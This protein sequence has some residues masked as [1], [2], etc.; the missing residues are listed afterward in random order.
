MILLSLKEA[1]FEIYEFDF[2]VNGV[3][4]HAKEGKTDYN[5]SDNT[6]V[7]IYEV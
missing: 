7:E 2:Y 1:L 4:Y 6:I 5:G 3:K